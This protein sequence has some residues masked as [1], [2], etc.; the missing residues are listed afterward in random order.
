MLTDAIGIE[1]DLSELQR[2]MEL[3]FHGTPSPAII[4]MHVLNRTRHSIL[5]E[6]NLVD[7]TLTI[8]ISDYEL[9]HL[10]HFQ[11]SRH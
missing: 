1:H 3:M 11:V 7:P 9:F 4:S 8:A 5:S 10:R 2:G 6:I